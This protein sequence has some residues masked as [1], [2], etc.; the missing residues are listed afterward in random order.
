MD[1]R[2]PGGVRRPIERRAGSLRPE[3]AYRDPG[4]RKLVHGSQRGREL[5]RI[6]PGKHPISLVEAPD[7]EQAPDLEILRMRG[8]HTI[9]VLFERCSRR[10]ERFR[11]PAEVARGER[12][13]GLGNDAPRTGHGLFRAERARSAPHEC[14]RSTEIAK[15]R[16]RDTSQ[17]KRRRIVTQ[18]N[19]LQRP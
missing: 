1:S 14:P 11:R 19:P 15:L 8:V 16:H 7:Q 3:A 18:R 4:G 5:R 9:A 13:L 12:D 6:E 17:R 2:L 10:V